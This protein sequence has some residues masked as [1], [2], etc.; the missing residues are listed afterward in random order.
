MVELGRLITI[1]CA[2]GEWG[3]LH[4][5]KQLI[6]CILRWNYRWVKAREGRAMRKAFGAGRRVK[7][8][9]IIYANRGDEQAR[10]TEK[11]R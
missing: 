10:L 2:G 3:I 5:Y 8:V 1:Q 11:I 6:G 7:I 9:G 4:V